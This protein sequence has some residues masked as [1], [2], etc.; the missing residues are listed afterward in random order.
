MG[1][2]EKIILASVCLLLMAS[3]VGE[4][5][6][7]GGGGHDPEPSEMEIVTA[8]ASPLST[9][10]NTRDGVS[11]LWE[12]KDEIALRCQSDPQ[13]VPSSCVYSTALAAAK[14]TASFKMV[15]GE[16]NIPDKSIGNYIAVY[17]ASPA[18]L[19]WEKDGHVVLAPSSW[20]TVRNKSMD[21]A[22]ALM[23][24]ASE[25]SEFH[26]SHVV[27]YIGFSIS[28]ATSPF[29]R[30][31][32]R[33]ADKSQSVVSRIRVG[34]DDG[35]SFSL[36]PGDASGSVSFSSADGSNLPEGRYLI[37][38]NPGNYAEGFDLSFENSSGSVAA[39]DVSGSF[40]ASP[41]EVIDLGTIGN[42][43]FKTTSLHGVVFYRDPSNSAKQKLVSAEGIISKWATSNGK[44][45]ISSFKEDPDYVHTVV[46][47][48]EQYMASP[49][50][51]PAVRFCEKMRKDYGG[52]WHLPSLTEINMLFNAYY[53]KAPFDDISK[54]QEYTDSGSQAAAGHFD[55]LLEAAGG[56]ALLKTTNDYWICAQN[57][58]TG[59]MQFV[60]MKKYE[61]GNAVQTE[62]KY[63]RCVRD[64]DETVSDDRII[65]PQTDVG[66]LI[67]G[68]LATSIVD[69]L[70]DTTYTVTEGLS[71]YQMKV[72]TDDPVDNTM[73]T[74]LVRADLSK[75]LDFKVAISD[76]T[77]PEYLDMKV[78]TELA[79]QTSTPSNPVYAMV[80]GDFRD[81][82]NKRPRGPLHSSGV[83]YWSTFSLDE[84][85]SHQGIS[86]IGRTNEGRMVIGE[87]DEYDSVKA[88]LTDCTGAGFVLVDMNSTGILAYGAARDPRTA[89]GYSSGNLIWMFAVDGR[90][91]GTEGM[92]Y[93]EMATIFYALGCEK[94]VNMDGG[95]STEMVVRNPKTGV[96]EVCNW[97]SDPTDGDGGV[98]RARPS[99]WAIVKK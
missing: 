58:A 50:D 47:N 5:P 46:T 2:N 94:A 92:N 6:D 43:E 27:S 38:V 89:I 12:N 40:S 60:N 70:W 32:V 67:K 52:N 81:I 45:R 69:V 77:T 90:H 86:Y 39:M 9:K 88:N 72:K 62:Q 16:K 54:N 33:S 97:P 34:F 75:G 57:A 24:A 96:I 23:I 74:Y 19:G 87:R 93:T 44:W 42:L 82:P 55:S 68:P 4:S 22:S 8:T 65:Y 25:D 3:C 73:D 49:A 20:Q 28:S 41:G 76:R 29:S 48:S 1:C 71:Y 14:A 36:L 61:N 84:A 91:K 99:A 21:K 53:G 10:L 98:E 37:A 66:R 59:N 15:T 63:V 31:T 78:L 56:E 85:Y 79:A 18:Y 51:F 7:T 26:F 83:I 35:F 80:N 13:A 30:I 17:P 64:V 11:L 95:G